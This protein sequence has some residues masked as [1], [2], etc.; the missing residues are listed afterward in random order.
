MQLADLIRILRS[1]AAAS[2]DELLGQAAQLAML[3]EDGQAETLE[4]AAQA[5]ADFCQRAAA[6]S[7]SLG[8]A[9]LSTMASTLA[10]GVVMA[11]ALPLELR[12]PAGP[13]LS[14]WP[15]FFAS[16]L[17]RWA[18]GSIDEAAVASLLENVAAAEFV[19]PLDE[20]QRA[21]LREQLCAP[22]SMQAQQADMTMPWQP[23]PDDALELSPE[24]DADPETLDGLLAEGPVLVQRLGEILDQL[25][26]GHAAPEQL[27]LA[28][29]NAHT[30]KGNAAVAGIRGVATLSHALEDVLEVFRSP[31]FTAPEGLLGIVLAACDQLEFAFEH[32]QN[33]TALPESFAPIAHALHAWACHLQGMEVPASML[34]ASGAAIP[35]PAPGSAGSSAPADAAT[36]QSAASDDEA[37]I[38]VPVKALDRIFRTVNELSIGMLRLRQQ[39]DDLLART[40]ALGGLEQIAAQRLLDIEHRVNV[41]GLGRSVPGSGAVARGGLSTGGDAFDALELDRYNELTGAAQAL[42]EAILDLR[43]ARQELVPSMR[44]TG[45]LLQRQLEFA[46]EAQYQMA[47]AR[48]RPLSDLRARLKRNVR[49]TCA[50]VG[51]EASLEIAGED[52]RV[53]AAVLGP[54]SDA[55]LH[56]LRNSI[57]HGIEPPQERLAAGKPAAGSIRL[58]FSNTGGGIVARLSDDG[59]G[60]DHEAILGKAIGKGLIAPDAQLSTEQISRLIFLPGFSTRDAVSETSGRGVGLDVVAQAVASLQG[61]VSVKSE[62]GQGTEFRLFVLPTVGTVHA[63]HVSV[64]SEHFLIPSVQL[65]QAEAAMADMPKSEEDVADLGQLLFGLGPDADGAPR[66]S[67]LL[68]VDGV[69]RRV[70]VDKV[71]EAR[72]FLIAPAPAMISRMPGITGVAALADGSTAIVLDL[73]D[74]ARQPVPVEIQSLREMQAAVAQ[75]PKVL[76][77]DDS[78]SVRNT[79]G[80]L[81]RDG[82]FEVA[83]ARDGLEGMRA[84]M[85]SPFAAV[86]TDLEMPQVNGFELTEYI[87]KRSGQPELPVVMLT[88]RGQN[89]HRMRAAEVGVDVFLVKP[90]S[91]QQLLDSLREVASQPSRRR[92]AQPQAATSEYTTPVGSPP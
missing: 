45:S 42:S 90:Y 63:L 18:A 16:Y 38:R 1:E 85:D 11:A 87:R 4:A 9:G 50:A 76:V 61:N 72:E 86:L 54:L 15:E 12:A 56:L 14:A 20:P 34:E 79:L 89:K 43:A 31:D 60:L 65:Q 22:P 62:R 23:L 58:V 83:T 71:L 29:R 37:Q 48:L 8:L 88:S 44:D 53:D 47:Q 68:D 84:V 46:R 28:H 59:R 35:S 66:P 26:R 75:L 51:R 25:A 91:D 92:L 70:A 33:R 82:G 64:H 69:R 41:E 13:L 52:L 17:E 73:L 77:V 5:Y 78:A 49:Q 67:L 80:Q 27:E 36:A 21:Q 55:L 6:A 32:L 24:S 19:T 74:L 30:L 2:R 10:E 40:E 57:D 81:L 7:A 3:H 39:N